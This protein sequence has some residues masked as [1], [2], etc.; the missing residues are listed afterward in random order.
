MPI[1]LNAEM[2]AHCWDM[3]VASSST[4]TKWN[5]PPSEDMKFKV[6][7]RKDRYAHHEVIGGIH[8]ICVSS[9]LVRRFDVLCSTLIHEAIHVHQDQTD[10]PRCDN[11]T[12]HAFA[13]VLCAEL[14]L[15]RG[16]F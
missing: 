9:V 8:Q 6:I 10:L 13:D 4:L 1:A 5:L 3:V 14:E 11:K 2:L 12:F 16:A 15:D 7:K